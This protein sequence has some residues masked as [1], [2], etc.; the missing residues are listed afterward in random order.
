[1]GYGWVFTLLGL[2]D[3]VSC[4]LAVVALRRWGRGWRD[5]RAERLK[6]REN[7]SV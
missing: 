3:A 4:V 6:E 2:F 1:L 5:R 7:E